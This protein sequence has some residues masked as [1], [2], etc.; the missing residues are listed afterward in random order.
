ME[1]MHHEDEDEDEDEWNEN[2]D[3]KEDKSEYVLEYIKVDNTS[4]IRLPLL[5]D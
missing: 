2:D 4:E 3:Y 5:G 1:C